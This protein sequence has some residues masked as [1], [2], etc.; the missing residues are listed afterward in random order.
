[1][2]VH[3]GYRQTP[4]HRAR[5]AAALR[6]RTVSPEMRARISATLTGRTLPV[7]TRAKMSAAH[8]G[9]PK[10]AEHRATMKA[11]YS[12]ERRAAMRALFVGRPRSVEIRVK[13]SVAQM[14]NRYMLDAPMKG[15]CVYCLGPAQ[16]HD[17]AIPRGRP[18]WDTP[19]NVVLACNRCN[20]SKGRRTPDE[21]LAAGLFAT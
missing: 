1:M 17:H 9:K 6:G 4:E 21:W 8:K 3:K 2:P 13:I 12:D 18:G 7:G 19:D 5:V 16:T 10:S 20:A 14:G 11:N 15:D